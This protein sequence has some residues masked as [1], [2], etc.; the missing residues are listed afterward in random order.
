M[1]PEL[2]SGAEFELPALIGVSLEDKVCIDFPKPYWL[3]GVDGNERIAPGRHEFEIYILLDEFLRF[4][5][6]MGDAQMEIHT[7]NNEPF[8]M[9]VNDPIYFLLRRETEE[10]VLEGRNEEIYEQCGPFTIMSFSDAANLFG[11]NLMAGIGDPE[12]ERLFPR[13]FYVPKAIAQPL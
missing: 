9:T 11:K 8:T 12:V 3:D 2:E 1:R 6:A 5:A 7:E 13:T 10:R 4:Q